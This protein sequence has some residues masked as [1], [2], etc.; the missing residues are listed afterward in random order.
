MGNVRN[1]IFSFIHNKRK[2]TAGLNKGLRIKGCHIMIDLDQQKT[3]VVLFEVLKKHFVDNSFI[4]CS[5][6]VEKK[7]T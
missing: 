3:C 6:D 7:I 2:N 5:D 4:L 1:I